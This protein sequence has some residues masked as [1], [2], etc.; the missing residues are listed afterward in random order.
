MAH[1]SGRQNQPLMVVGDLDR[2]CGEQPLVQKRGFHGGTGRPSPPPPQPLRCTVP[3]TRSLSSKCV[4]L[5]TIVDVNPP[6]PPMF[7]AASSSM[8]LLE[9]DESSLVGGLQH[10]SAYLSPQL[11]PATK[12][13]PARL[14]FRRRRTGMPAT[15]WT[16][17]PRDIRC[18][19]RGVQREH[20]WCLPRRGRKHHAAIR[21]CTCAHPCG[22]NA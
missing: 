17:I 2:E 9:L 1:L 5:V 19:L 6:T 11:L 4:E 15:T 3:S 16:A 18:S 14:A 13:T 7:G 8:P 12:Y 21:V 20:R 22:V 10:S